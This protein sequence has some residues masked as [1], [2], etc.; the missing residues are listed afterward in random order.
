MQ[1]SLG[2]LNDIIETHYFSLYF[3]HMFLDCCYSNT[4]TYNQNFSVNPGSGIERLAVPTL[5]SWQF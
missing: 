3:L 5:K 2:L 4:A 1:Q